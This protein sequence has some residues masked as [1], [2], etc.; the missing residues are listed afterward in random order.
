MPKLY[1]NITNQNDILSV[2]IP[3]NNE[4]RYIGDCLISLLKQDLSAGILEIIIVANGCSDRTVSIAEKFE[5]RITARDWHLM[6]L[7]TPKGSKT[8]AL[9]IADEIAQGG[10][11]VYLDA[12]VTCDASL[13][14]QLR[15]VIACDNPLYVTGKLQ[16][17]EARS[18]I[19]R[20][21]AELWTRLPFIKDGAAGAGFFAVNNSGRARWGKFPN[22]I[23]DDTFVR[24]QFAQNERIEVEAGYRWPMAEGF[25]NLAHVRHRQN[26]GVKELHRMFPE[27]LKNECKRKLG[28]TDI[29][30]LFIATPLGFI[31]YAFVTITVRFMGGNSEWKRGR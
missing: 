27:L 28:A 4:E 7:E 25:K 31:T 24:L 29:V 26:V 19:T 15:N 5:T 21:Y 17:A 2:I 23:S 20:Y 3:A 8:N 18:L 12:D 13:L 14:G 10:A 22:I 11:R 30:H 1:P 16:V 9:N 6:I